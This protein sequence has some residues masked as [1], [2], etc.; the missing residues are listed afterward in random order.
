MQWLTPSHPWEPPHTSSSQAAPSL[1][2]EGEPPAERGK[3]LCMGAGIFPSA[4]S[5][6]SFF[7]NLSASGGI[8]SRAAFRA[9]DKEKGERRR[10]LTD[11]NYWV[12]LSESPLTRLL[13]WQHLWLWTT[14]GRVGCKELRRNCVETCSVVGSRLSACHFL[15]SFLVW[16]HF[17]FYPCIFSE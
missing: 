10:K 15:E 8:L 9:T 6:S 12:R 13:L 16:I 3:E 11:V 4:R 7:S 1:P 2:G 14:L 17:F 5:L